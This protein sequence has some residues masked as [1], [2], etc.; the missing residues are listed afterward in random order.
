MGDERRK[1]DRRDHSSKDTHRKSKDSSESTHENRPGEKAGGPRDRSETNA[2][3]E[4]SERSEQPRYVPSNEDRAAAGS[5][6]TDT[7]PARVGGTESSKKKTSSSTLALEKLDSICDKLARFVGKQSRSREGESIL[8]N[9]HQIVTNLGYR[10]VNLAK[11][12]LF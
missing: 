8:A 7:P 3:P 9:S 10:S 1:E 5:S 11:F 2:P 12:G 4:R 6:A